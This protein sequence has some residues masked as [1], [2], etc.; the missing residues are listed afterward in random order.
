MDWKKIAPWNWFKEEGVPAPE[1]QMPARV[2][3]SSDPFA[4]LR[5][6]MGQLFDDPFRGS[7]PGWPGRPALPGQILTSLR[8]SVDIS[9]GKKAYMVRAELP[10]VELEDVSIEIDG[11]TLVIRAEKRQETEEEEEDYHCIERSYGAVQRVLSLP[12]DADAEAIEAKFKN[13]VLKL[14]IPKHAARASN[15]RSIEIEGG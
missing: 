8:P 9:E 14:R 1:T 2:Y 13:A 3:P 5:T 6:Q 10:G 12:D 11:H 15:A 4:A 7:F